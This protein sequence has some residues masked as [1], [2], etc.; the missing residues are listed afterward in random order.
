MR[1][2]TTR[3]STSTWRAHSAWRSVSI[4][5][6]TTTLPWRERHVWP[7]GSE[8][9]VIVHRKAATPAGADV[10]GIIPWPM[11]MPGYVVRGRGVAAS[12]NSASH[13][14]GPAK[15]PDEGEA[16]VDVGRW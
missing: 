8:R 1:Q 4:S 7:D 9:D 3:S 6:T 5:R 16:D 12:L 10:V 15:E 13:G 14:R 11:G 2:P